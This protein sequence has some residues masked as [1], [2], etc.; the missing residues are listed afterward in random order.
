MNSIRRLQGTF[1]VAFFL[2][3][4]SNGFSQTR[5]FRFAWLSDT[6][7]GSTTGTADLGAS[8]RDINTLDSI[9]FVILSGDI[10]EMGFDAQLEQAKAILDSLKK[11]YYII[12]GN[13]DT[14]W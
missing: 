3:I 11:P 13:H 14:K 8:V 5:P 10:T 12:P 6:H 9:A 4:W 2:L 1:L 7:V